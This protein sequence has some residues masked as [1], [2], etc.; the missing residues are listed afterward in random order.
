MIPPNLIVHK[1]EVELT[2]ELVGGYL[3]A[4][5]GCDNRE[6]L[7]GGSPWIA[8]F[9]EDA[10]CDPWAWEEVVQPALSD[11]LGRAAFASTPRG[12]ESFYRKWALGMEPGEPD[13]RSWCVTTAEAGAVHPS[14][15]AR[16][17]RT[18]P[19]DMYDQEY[20]AKFLGY[21]GLMVPEF[22]PRPWPEG[23]I[24]PMEMW[25]KFYENATFWGSGDYG[26]GRRT[27]FHWYAGDSQGRVVQFWEYT[28]EGMSI[29]AQVQ[30]DLSALD[31]RLIDRKIWRALDKSCWN[32]EKTS[33]ESVAFQL[34]KGPNGIRTL[35]ADGDFDAS[36]LALRNLCRSSEDANGQYIPPQFMVL[37]GTC[38]V[39]THELCT[40]EDSGKGE[41]GE[42][43]I[44]RHCPHDGF[45]STRYGIMFRRR[46]RTM[47]ST[48]S[49]ANT[50]QK[51]PL[52]D[53]EEM[54]TA[55]VSGLPEY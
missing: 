30:K 17:R 18:M 2:V 13:W 34:G 43:R 22:I 11:K 42:A 51:L 31:K 26:T 9:D 27:V 23:N 36:W 47:P 46:A 15:L 32:K 45:D 20:N 55:S 6:S 3:L 40:V 38:P 16:L 48:A 28:G 33:T 10:Y 52:H 41:T 24:M 7:R 5:K 53:D 21:T 39:A 50:E 49:Y 37:E 54:A 4:L 29:P 1:S 35:P 25:P 19:R 8:V 14:E 12:K 44:A